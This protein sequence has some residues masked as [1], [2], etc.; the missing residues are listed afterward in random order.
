MD[1]SAPARATPRF[2]GQFVVPAVLVPLLWVLLQGLAVPDGVITFYVVS[3]G[4]IPIAA[5]AVLL[6]GWRLAHDAWRSARHW[7]VPVVVLL[8][9]P[10]IAVVLWG[11]Y[12][13]VLLGF[14]TIT[15]DF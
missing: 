5:A 9:L 15:W 6:P 4:A 2:W 12:T 14:L 11:I 1:T 7:L 3:I 8:M 13:A 10:T